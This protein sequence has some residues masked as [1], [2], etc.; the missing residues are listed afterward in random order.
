MSGPDKKE[1]LKNE[2][3]KQESYYTHINHLIHLLSMHKLGI[4][5]LV[6]DLLV[7]AS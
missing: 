3:I 6:K 7:T 2:D 5:L 4:P 1:L